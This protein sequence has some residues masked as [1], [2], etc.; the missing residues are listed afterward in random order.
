[1]LQVFATV[2]YPRCVIQF[3]NMEENSIYPFLGVKYV[4]DEV[5]YVVMF[6]EKDMG[7]VV[8]C[9][10]QIDGISLGFYGEFDETQFEY[11]NPEYD[12]I[13]NND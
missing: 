13:L 6:N 8:Q 10:G 1:M 9:K 7:M 4:S 12:V 2:H 11:V 3:I 5:Y